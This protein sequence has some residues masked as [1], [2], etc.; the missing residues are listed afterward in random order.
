[1]P[2]IAELARGEKL[3]M[4]VINHSL[5]HPAYLMCREPKLSSRNMFH[6]F[7]THAWMDTQTDGHRTDVQPKKITAEV[8]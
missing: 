6:N 1:M 4:Q 5:T 7:E 2:S 3:H 8:Q